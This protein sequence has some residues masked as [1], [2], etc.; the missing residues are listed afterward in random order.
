MEAFT[1]SR[2]HFQLQQM[3]IAASL[4]CVSIFIIISQPFRTPMPPGAVNSQLTPDQ[5]EASEGLQLTWNEYLENYYRNDRRPIPT[6]MGIHQQIVSAV[7]SG[8]NNRVAEAIRDPDSAAFRMQEH[9]VILGS[10]HNTQKMADNAGIGGTQASLSYTDS[11]GNKVE[12]A[13]SDEEL[14]AFAALKHQALHAALVME[15]DPGGDIDAAWLK[16]T[17][18]SRRV[19]AA[20]RNVKYANNRKDIARDVQMYIDPT[21]ISMDGSVH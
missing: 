2:F 4:L 8:I 10:I 18:L 21:V 19:L 1:L 9:Q 6:E 5:V 7:A 3:A 12:I 17:S 20:F 14:Q 13:V 15:R 11:E 16:E